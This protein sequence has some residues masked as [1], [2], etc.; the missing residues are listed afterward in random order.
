MNLNE[1][2]R[3]NRLHI[4]I[5]GKRNSGKSTLINALTGQTTSLVSEIAGTTTDPVYKTIEIHGIGPCVLIDTA[6]FDDAGYLGAMRVDK[7]RTAM[8]KTDIAL[9]L[10]TDENVAM[11][12][13]WFN[14]LRKRNTPVIPLINKI[15][16]LQD[17]NPIRRKIKD[18]CKVEPI[19]ISAQEKI[20]IELIREAILRKLPEDY[21]GRDI[22]GKLVQ[23]DDLVLLVMPQDIQAPK[24]RLILPQ[25]QTIRELLDKKCIVISCTADKLPQALA[26]LSKPPKLIITDSQVFPLVNQA[27]PKESLLTSF[28]VLFAALKGDIDYFIKSAAMID[29]L[30]INS[31]VL[32]AEA[33]THVPLQEDIGTVKIPRLLREKIGEGLTIINMHGNDFPEDLT[34]YDLIIQCG[35]CMFNRKFVLNRVAKAKKQQVPMTNYGIALAHLSGILDK[36]ST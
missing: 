10:F 6:G 19:C 21:D 8:E 24:G 15:D 3:S 20:G 36:I 29:R 18:I 23:E 5:F 25:V 11:E 13:E 14:E 16:L 27:K 35:S 32:I 4:G 31:K 1:T 12:L 33:C 34:N 22:T 30:T 17:L 9:I 26:T 28:S 7:T 2:P